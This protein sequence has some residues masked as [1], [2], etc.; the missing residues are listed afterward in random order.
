MKKSK[1]SLILNILI[2]A[3]VVLG[4]VFMFTGIK[5]MPSNDSLVSTKIEMFKYFTVDSNI[6]M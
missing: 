2:V 6:F 1:I 5:F 4:T 3:F